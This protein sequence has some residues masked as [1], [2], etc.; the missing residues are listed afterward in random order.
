MRR[1]TRAG[2]KRRIS[3]Y[4]IAIGSRIAGNRPRP[5]AGGPADFEEWL[6]RRRGRRSGAYPDSWR[7]IDEQ[8][9]AEPARIGVVMHAFYAELVPELIDGLRSMPVDFDLIVTNASG[10]DLDLDLTGL[11]HLRNSVVLPIENHGRDIWPLVAVVNAGLLDPYEIVLKVHTKKSPWREEHAELSGTGDEWKDSFHRQL[12]G[13]RTNVERILTAFRTD[14]GLGMLTADGN[15]LGPQFWG[16]NEL[17]VRALLRRLELDMASD[18]LIFAAGSM[19]WTRAFVLQGLRALDLRVGDFEPEIGHIDGTTAHAIERLLG[20]VSVEAGLRVLGRSAIDEDAEPRWQD[21]APEA[22]RCPRVRVVPFYLPQFHRN[23]ENDRWWGP[24]F[25]EWQNVTAASP[26][27]EGHHQPRLPGELGFYDLDLDAVRHRQ[28]SMA[29]TH[30]VEGFMYYYYWFAGQRL[31]HRPIEALHRDSDLDQP[32]CI[33]WANENW[34]R[35]WDGRNADLLMAQDYDRVPATAFIDDVM[36]FLKDERYI[37]VDGRPVISVYRVAQ[38]PEYREVFDH[39]RRRAREEGL[40]ELLILNVDVVKE[41]D[42]LDVTYRDAGLDGT[43]AFPPHN[44]KWDWMS[45]VGLGVDPAF[46]GNI[47]SYGSVVRHAEQDLADLENGEFPGVM[48]TF[49][50]TARRQWSSDVWFGSNPYTFRRWIAAT[51]RSLALRDPQHRI[52]FVN[53]WN[54]WAE[55]AVLEP[56][57]RHGATYLAAIRDVVFG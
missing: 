34:S 9:F 38:I 53:A 47:L 5:T 46:V 20:V 12:L 6:K 32:F 52:V 33:M 45:H 7:T 26:V 24:G 55:G 2:I 41:F 19:Y 39:W 21:Y 35:R 54:E 1:I 56:T 15:V 43:H 22:A 29:R 23:D 36:E 13:E 18:D 37:R 51:A 30:G 25:T 3:R 31:L 11:D 10:T 14:Q 28:A 57:E 16:G 4:R 17:T 8:P 48:V 27:F 40:G 50:N 42:G 49:D 44:S